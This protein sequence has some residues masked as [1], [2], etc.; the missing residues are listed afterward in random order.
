M[1]FLVYKTKG[2][3]S[4]RVTSVDNLNWLFNQALIQALYLTLEE[5]IHLRSSTRMKRSENAP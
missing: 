5:Q 4:L 2:A 1:F 3:F